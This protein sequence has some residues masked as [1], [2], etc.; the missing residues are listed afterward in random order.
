M[1]GF[2]QPWWCS[3]CFESQGSVPGGREG[4]KSGDTYIHM[5]MFL[6]PDVTIC[7]RQQQLSEA[8]AAAASLPADET[9]VVLLVWCSTQ[10][11]V[12][13]NVAKAVSPNRTKG[14]AAPSHPAH[15]DHY[16]HL[17][18]HL[19]SVHSSLHSAGRGPCPPHTT[20]TTTLP[21]PSVL[22]LLPPA[23]PRLPGPQGGTTGP[24]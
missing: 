19:L 6:V 8:V 2:L 17:S 1:S 15:T 5:L 14:T 13:M 10:H 16:R 21:Q 20:T 3:K 7:I 11:R 22:L 23:S 24:V 12:K 18:C 4:G 9:T